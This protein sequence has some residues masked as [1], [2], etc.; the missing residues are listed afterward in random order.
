ME[1][2]NVALAPAEAEG[3]W[4]E[5]PHTFLG[6]LDR[7]LLLIWVQILKVA[8]RFVSN[9][10]MLTINCEGGTP[11]DKQK[12]ACICFSHNGK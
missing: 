4:K 6:L 7:L 11:C 10:K 8:G 9:L 3:P 1:G 12:L 5:G 2:A